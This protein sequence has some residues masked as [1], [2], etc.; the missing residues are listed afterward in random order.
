MNKNVV[1]YSI[2]VS[3]IIL[4]VLIWSILSVL[5]KY[6]GNVTTIKDSLSIISSF[7]G[8]LAT[9]GA[10]LIAANLFNDWRDQHNKSVRNQ[11]SIEAYNKFSELEQSL[12]LCL[13]DIDTLQASINDS[14]YAITPF[15]PRYQECLPLV[16]EIFK[17]LILIKM[18]F[19]DYVGKQRSYGAVSGQFDKINKNLDDYI[20]EFHN[21]DKNQKNG[22]GDIQSLI[23]AVGGEVLLYL[24]LTGRI[25]YSTIQEMLN[26]LQ[27]Y[28]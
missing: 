10:A 17:K 7:F 14:D 28:D 18:N 19:S 12:H 24:N 15:T 6:W 11:F 1:S 3:V 5:F 20:M 21:I 2:I 23:T 25:Y 22:F 13:F 8:G 27:A 26:H 16:E 9:L 4:T